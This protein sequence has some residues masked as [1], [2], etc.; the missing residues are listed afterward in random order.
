MAFECS[1][2]PECS[3]EHAHCPAES[4]QV[5]GQSRL[6]QRKM[7]RVAPWAPDDFHSAFSVTLQPSPCRL[8]PSSGPVTATD[9]VVRSAERKTPPLALRRPL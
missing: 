1:D 8:V 4:S 5:T 2:R 7:S 3:V 6:G 9:G